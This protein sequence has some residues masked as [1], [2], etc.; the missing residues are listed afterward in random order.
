[1]RIRVAGVSPE[2]LPPNSFFLG[3]QDE[4]HRYK[5]IIINDTAYYSTDR[6]AY[7]ALKLYRENQ[8][9]DYSVDIVRT[10]DLIKRGRR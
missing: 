8:R 4:R 1:M 3:F 6:E 9:L 5:A 2:E 10:S 7:E